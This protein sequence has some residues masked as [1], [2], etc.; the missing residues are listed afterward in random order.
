[1]LILGGDKLSLIDRHPLLKWYREQ[2]KAY[3]S[4]PD[5]RLMV[6]GYGIGDWH[7]NEMIYQA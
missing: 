3:M 6:I 2:F 5:T 4:K 1:M 7:I